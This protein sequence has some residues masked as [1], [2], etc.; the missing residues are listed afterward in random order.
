VPIILSKSVWR[1]F[2]ENHGKRSEVQRRIA[3]GEACR[4]LR[5]EGLIKKKH[6]NLARSKA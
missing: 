3:E 6:K 5:D 2:D 1:F 4:Y